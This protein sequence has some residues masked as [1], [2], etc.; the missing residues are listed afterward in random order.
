LGWNGRMKEMDLM[1]DGKKV[2]FKKKKIIGM[3][4]ISEKLLQYVKKEEEN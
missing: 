4:W 1:L 3:E 2:K